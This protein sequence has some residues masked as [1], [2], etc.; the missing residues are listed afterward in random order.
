MQPSPASGN[1]DARYARPHRS[2][3]PVVP[4]VVT[5]L[6]LAAAPFAISPLH[7]VVSL[8]EVPGATLYHPAGYLA[9]APVSNVLDT[10]SLLTVHQH[11]A[12]FATVGAT[13][14]AWRILR[15]R[16]RA[17]L[18]HRVGV[19]AGSFALLLLG[20]LAVYSALTLLDRPMSALRLADPELVAVDF[21]AHTRHSHDGRDGWTPETVRG[22]L[23]G[24]GFHAAY[25]TDHRR[26]EG[27]AAAVAGNPRRAGDGVSMFSGIEVISAR[28]HLNVL[29]ATIAD[30][31]YFRHRVVG[32][33]SIRAFRPAD[34]GEPVIL[35]TIPGRLSR[36]T[37]EMK[38][39]AIEISDAAPRG[40]G[41]TQRERA[42]ILRMADTLDLAPLAASDNHGWG[43]TAVSWSLLRIAG[44]RAMRP[45]SLDRAIRGKLLRERGA[46][47]QTLERRRIDPAAS[48]LGLAGTVP[49]FGWLMLRTLSWPERAAWIAWAW[50]VW[51][52][53]RAAGTRRTERR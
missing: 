42:A 46:A 14:L 7:D 11:F 3:I 45:D 23:R 50:G 30:S 1:D 48:W 20:L 21:H 5:A 13:Y 26:F 40:L 38:L 51:L 18:L 27:A 24:G 29:G 36:V 47:A 22:W 8:A 35:L 43:R 28:L 16:R 17:T 39:H 31:A 10:L 19:E 25:V 53:A 49:E 6:V 52:A 32:P 9:V 12:L 41:A 4:G 37:P 34:G 44:W 15:G 33:D 2:R